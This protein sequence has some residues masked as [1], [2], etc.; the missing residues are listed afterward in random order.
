MTDLCHQYQAIVFTADEPMKWGRIFSLLVVYDEMVVVE[1]GSR[2]KSKIACVCGMRFPL[3]TRL[4]G[5]LYYSTLLTGN[6]GGGPDSSD[7]W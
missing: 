3:S 1:L 7:S 2:K 6:C 5:K 4:R